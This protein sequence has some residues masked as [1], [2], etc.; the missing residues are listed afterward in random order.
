M[1]IIIVFSEDTTDIRFGLLDADAAGGKMIMWY[2]TWASTSIANIFGTW[3]VIGVLRHRRFPRVF[4]NAAK[5]FGTGQRC[6]GC[7][8]SFDI[9][10]NGKYTDI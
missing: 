7:L 8:H 4:E 9:K 3:T 6:K 2:P 10:E 1:T 5:L